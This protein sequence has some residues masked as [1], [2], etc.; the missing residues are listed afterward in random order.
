MI[1]DISRNHHYYYFPLIENYVIADDEKYDIIPE[2][3]EGHNVADFIDPEIKE[4]ISGF[5]GYI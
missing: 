2:L 3:W 5:Q 1:S 4:V